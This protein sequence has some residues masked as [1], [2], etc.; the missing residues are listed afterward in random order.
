[1]LSELLEDAGTYL[2]EDD[3]D[4]CVRSVVEELIRKGIW[5]LKKKGPRKVLS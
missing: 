3:N 2:D 1:M 4:T 5:R